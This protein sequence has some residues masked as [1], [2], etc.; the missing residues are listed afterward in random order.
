MLPSMRLRLRAA[1]AA[2]AGR[3]ARGAPPSA[4][5]PSR[6]S[7]G[8]TGPSRWR[9]RARR[10][11]GSRPRGVAPSGV[12]REPPSRAVRGLAGESARGGHRPRHRGTARR[13]ARERSSSALGCLPATRRSASRL[14]SSSAAR[15][16]Q[17][18]PS[19]TPRSAARACRAP[20][21]TSG[22]TSASVRPGVT[23]R[24]GARPR[25]RRCPTRAHTDSRLSQVR[26]LQSCHQFTP[27][28][29][30]LNGKLLETTYNE[31][32]ASRFAREGVQCQDCHMPDRRHRWRGIHDPDD[33][34]LG[35]HDHREAVSARGTVRRVAPSR[36]A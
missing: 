29:F 4:P 14:R 31:W 15:R 24:S 16:L 27:D 28:G 11:R 30:A 23:A 8:V 10:P 12:V 2:A 1:G 33:G 22:A 26:I 20:A 32:K 6:I 25:G 36:C 9:R 7:S 21:A 35:P 3:A 18:N 17:P 19:T 34:A 13:D 5:M